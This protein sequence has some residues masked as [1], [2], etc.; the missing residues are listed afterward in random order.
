MVQLVIRTPTL[1]TSLAAE[2]F[3]RL[4]L[5]SAP[6]R[7]ESR[8]D[9]DN[10]QHSQPRQQHEW[11]RGLYTKKQGAQSAVHGQGQHHTSDTP[12]QHES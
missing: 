5:G 12:R 11:I 10:Q 7:N 8:R 3:H 6:G 1:M 9:R 2:R 4:D